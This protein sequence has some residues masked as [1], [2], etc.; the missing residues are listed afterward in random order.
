MFESQPLSNRLRIFRVSETTVL[1]WF[2]NA[3]IRDGKSARF[4]YVP[5]FNGLPDDVKV[6]SV[7]HEPRDRRFAFL[8]ESETFPETFPGEIIP[9]LQ[10]LFGLTYRSIDLEPEKRKCVCEGGTLAC[11]DPRVSGMLP[12]LDPDGKIP[13]LCSS[14]EG[15]ALMEFFRS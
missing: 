2:V 5:V 9:D 13:E 7:R 1:D 6:H 3:A 15:D 4:I 12:E 11:D 10:G 8:L 14:S